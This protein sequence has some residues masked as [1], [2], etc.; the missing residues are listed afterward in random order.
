MAGAALL[1]GA[2]VSV[3]AVGVGP[4]AAHDRR[5]G[6]AL[7]RAEIGRARVSVH[8]VGRALTAQRR[9]G[10]RADVGGTT[11]VGAGLRVGALEVEVT[12]ARDHRVG[13]LAPRAAHR[14][15][16]GVGG[17][18]VGRDGAAA[19]DRFVLA[20]VL[21]VA[22]VSGA[23][24][25]VAAVGP[26]AAA[27]G[28][29]GVRAGPAR[30]AIGGAGVA[31]VAIGGS[32]AAAGGAIVGA[33]AADAT[34]G[35]ASIAVV[36]VGRDRAAAG[37]G[38]RAR[39]ARTGALVLGTSVA[40]RAV[41]VMVTAAGD[42]SVAADAEVTRLEGAGVTVVAV[43]RGDAAGAGAC[44][45]TDPGRGAAVY[46]TTIEVIAALGGAGADADAD[47]GRRHA[48]ARPIGDDRGQHVRPAG[49]GGE[50]ARGATVAIAGVHGGGPIHEELDVGDAAADLFIVDPHR[51]HAWRQEIS[52]M[53]T[54]DGSG[55]R[56]VVEAQRARGGLGPDRKSVV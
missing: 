6:A 48:V 39:A 23:V 51:D 24:V 54:A 17:G 31:V 19:L 46:R 42:R 47:G 33:G 56:H 12:A 4:A 14:L 44:V 26:G 52:V 37:R 25:P 13:A 15:A 50:Q 30:A 35:G 9:D 32:A 40:V 1:G 41:K 18:A 10:V 16:A 2:G 21:G 22:E 43:G 5:V 8:A 34:I 11:I 49:Q 53:G 27:V 29:G 45:D 38:V 7:S 20:V 36:A 28:D 3:I 55:G